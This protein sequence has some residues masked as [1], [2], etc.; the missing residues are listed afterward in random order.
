MRVTIVADVLGIENNGTTITAVN[1]INSL[2]NKG[3]EVSVVC[4]DE[5]ITGL[6]GYYVVPPLNL[7]FLNN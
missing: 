4:P 3:L 7:G 5:N 6:Y 2:K 1:F